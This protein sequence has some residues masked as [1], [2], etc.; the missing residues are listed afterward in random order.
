M[1]VSLD[2]K[3]GWRGAVHLLAELLGGA[4]IS[5]ATLRLNLDSAPFCVRE[6]YVVVEDRYGGR[7]CGATFRGFAKRSHKLV[8]TP[9]HNNQI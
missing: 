2:S 6:V 5:V 9:F 4:T 1:V 3:G 8:T 7:L